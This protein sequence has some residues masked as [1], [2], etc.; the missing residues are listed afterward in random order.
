VGALLTPRSA[1]RRWARPLVLVA[2]AA[3]AAGL[4]A[5]QLILPT[6]YAS[7]TDVLIATFGAWIGFVVA[8]RARVARAQEQGYASH[9]WSA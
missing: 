1:G 9:S 4:E 5:G 3:L 8:R 7:I 2:A 6:H